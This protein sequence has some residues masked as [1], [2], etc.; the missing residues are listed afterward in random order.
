MNYYWRVKTRLPERQGMLCDV[1]AR[2]KK[3]NCLV[4]FA[5]GY[6]V[7]TSRNYVRRIPML[8]GMLWFDNSKIALAEKIAKAV[9]YYHKKYGRTPD[10]CLVHPS[11]LEA[12]QT[13]VNKI[14]VRPYR[15][16]L[17]GHI[18]IGMEDKEPT[19]NGA[20]KDKES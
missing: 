5:D 9:E 11:M 19:D 6:K 20:E 1:L 14:N 17:P 2:G 12:N 8:T 18:W 10:L 16:V 7:V 15:V 4:Q 13:E 3:N